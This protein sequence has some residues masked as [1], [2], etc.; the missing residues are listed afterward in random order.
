MSYESKMNQ[1]TSSTTIFLA[2]DEINKQQTLHLA[3]QV[4]ELAKWKQSLLSWITV[5]YI[6][7]LKYNPIITISICNIINTK[8]VWV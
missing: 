4:T 5:N 8:M 3:S 6:D 1:S 7:S 2:P